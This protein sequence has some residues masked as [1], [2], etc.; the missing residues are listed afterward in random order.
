MK[1]TFKLEQY[2]RSAGQKKRRAERG[3]ARGSFVFS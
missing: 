3:F 1:K 2:Q